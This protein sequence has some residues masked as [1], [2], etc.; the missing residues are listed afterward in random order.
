MKTADALFLQGVQKVHEALADPRE[1]RQD[2]TLAA[3]MILGIFEMG[4]YPQECNT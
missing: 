4:D 2:P 3:V 1:V